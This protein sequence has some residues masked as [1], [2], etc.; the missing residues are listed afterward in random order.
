MFA[1]MNTLVYQTK[2]WH[3]DES[4]LMASFIRVFMNLLIVIGLSYVS[5]G[6]DGHVLGIRGLFGDRRA[7]LWLRGFFGTLSVIAVF[8]AVHTIGS[9]E[10]SLLNA[11][12]AIW[13]GLFSPWL[14]KQKNSRLGWIAIFLGIFGLFLVYQPDFSSLEFL[15]RTVA[16]L[17]G[18]FGACAYMLVARAGRSN[19][20]L[21]VVFYFT[22]VASLAHLV[23]FLVNAPRWPSDLRNGMTLMAAGLAASLAQMYMTKAY[24]E[25]PAALVAAVSYLT[26]V[27]NMMFAVLLFGLV[28]N[29]AAI[30]GSCLVVLSGVLLPFVQGKIS[31][32]RKLDAGVHKAL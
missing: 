31:E 32:S 15:G 14:L 18:F 17:S 3:A 25:A 28:P 26:P 29:Q 16:L 21:S 23:L 7:S 6:S 2:V 4:A 11:S 24:M 12:N 22:L 1:I 20:P 8:Y 5:R 30:W 9:G 27:L 13:I 10:A 19:H